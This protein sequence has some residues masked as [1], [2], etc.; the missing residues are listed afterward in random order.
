MPIS[1][2][3]KKGEFSEC[4][5]HF[6]GKA[7]KRTG[8]PTTSEEARKICGSLQASQEKETKFC[9]FAKLQ[10]KEF[11]EDFHVSGYVATSHPDRAESEG[12]E[13]DIIPKS[14]LQGIVTDINNKYKPQ[15]GAVSERHDHI[16]AEDVD[17]PIAGVLTP[18]TVATLQELPDGEWGAHVDT[19][20]SK[21]NPRYE[22]VKTNIEQGIYPGFSIEFVTNDSVPVEKEGKMY[23]MLTDIDTEGFGYANRRMIANPHAEYTDFGYKEIAKELHNPKEDIE[24]AKKKKKKGEN[25]MEEKKKEEKE[26]TPEST[27][28]EDTP[29]EETPKEPEGSGAKVN[30]NEGKET[31]EVS[32]KEWKLLQKFKEAEAKEAREKELEPIIKEKVKAMLKEKGFRDAPRFNTGKEDKPE[33]KE[34]DNYQAALAS[35][36]ELDKHMGT[37]EYC[38]GGAKRDSLFQQ[39][40]DKQWKESGRLIDAL[41]VKGVDVY[42][43]W[44]KRA[45]IPK[46][47]NFKENACNYSN[48]FDTIG[49]RMEMKELSRVNRI[50]VKAGEGAQVDTN[51]ADDSWTYG[52]Y[53]LS[54]FCFHLFSFSS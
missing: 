50:E 34:L 22:E 43:N 29:K 27:G 51:L 52:S 33:F 38:V 35:M 1:F 46:P 36:K 13:G 5:T 41:M 10:L 15:A 24:K 31:K 9:S 3:G 6:T 54:P 23:R 39:S 2:D 42:G 12:F 8:K 7:N 17:M 32:E 45:P 19:I 44:L 47:S 21:T 4:I 40:I 25:K 16:Q 28:A 49:R 11:K 53:F 48:N 18:G 30:T 20:L 14:T 26:D 37:S